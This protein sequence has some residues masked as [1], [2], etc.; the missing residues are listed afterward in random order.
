AEYQKQ[1]ARRK[2]SKI[3]WWVVGATAALAVVAV[4]VASF[5]FAPAPAPSYQAGGS[6]GREIEGV[7]TFQNRSDY[8]QGSVTYD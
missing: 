5:V 8:V 3:V 1:I 7:Q 2:R 6:T 4:V